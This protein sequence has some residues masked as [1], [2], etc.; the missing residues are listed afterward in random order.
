[1]FPILLHTLYSTE[2][3]R[4]QT[5]WLRSCELHWGSHWHRKEQI[6]TRSCVGAPKLIVWMEISPYTPPLTDTDTHLLGSSPSLIE[7]PCRVA[8]WGFVRPGLSALSRE[9]DTQTQTDRRSP[10]NWETRH[11]NR[12]FLPIYTWCTSHPF[13]QSWH[14]DGDCTLYSWKIHPID[15]LVI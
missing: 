9:T 15:V 8:L 2:T 7:Q 10:G 5:V 6:I 3:I 11:F 12:H 14:L 1:M 13:S 4:G